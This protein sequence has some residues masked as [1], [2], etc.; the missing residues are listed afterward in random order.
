MKYSVIVGEAEPIEI[1]EK[2]IG[3]GKPA[4]KKAP[5]KNPKTNK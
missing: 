5:K 3:G 1:A 4:K 2:Q